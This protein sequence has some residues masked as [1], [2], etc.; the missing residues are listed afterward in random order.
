MEGNFIG[1]FYQDFCFGCYIILIKL[2]FV[3][4]AKKEKSKKNKEKDWKKEKEI[5]F[6][7]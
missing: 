6:K 2:K 1:F 5:V 4:N 7:K 3:E